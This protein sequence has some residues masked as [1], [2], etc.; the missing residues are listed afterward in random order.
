MYSINENLPKTKLVKIQAKN[1]KTKK[2]KYQVEEQD[3]DYLKQVIR[4][5]NKEVKR[6]GG[7]MEK[8]LQNSKEIEAL[9]NRKKT[10]K[11][12][13]QTKKEEQNIENL[14]QK[15]QQN[16]NSRLQNK[17]CQEPPQNF[18][19]E[20]VD[21]NSHV[22]PENNNSREGKKSKDSGA[23]STNNRNNNNDN[24][25]FLQKIIRENQKRLS[26]VFCSKTAKILHCS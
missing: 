9:L 20:E 24:T 16:T 1:N 4:N 23:K 22:T 21:L 2:K 3:I 10:K 6:G 19:I 17:T 8:L 25:N 12:N 13:Y 14:L 26:A 18:K 15:S 11:Q 5:K 7:K